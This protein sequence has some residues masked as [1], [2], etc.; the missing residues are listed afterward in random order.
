MCFQKD[1]VYYS[2]E[3]TEAGA[4]CWLVT[5]HPCSASNERCMHALYT[6]LSFSTSYSPA[7]PAQKMVPPTS[8]DK[9][10]IIPH[11]HAH[12]KLILQSREVTI[13]VTPC[14]LRL[15]G[16][17]YLRSICK[18]LKFGPTKWIG[19]SGHFWPSLMSSVPGTHMLE[20][21][22]QLQTSICTL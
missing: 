2:V 12:A 9:I 5:S 21:K 19:R 11:R 1:T 3:D 15:S 22:D 8:I 6:A 17:G 10:K 16:T 4:G 20:G 7:S 14:S 13:T 18:H